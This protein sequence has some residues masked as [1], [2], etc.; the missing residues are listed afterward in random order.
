VQFNSSDA[1][2]GL[3]T[4]PTELVSLSLE[5]TG[6]SATRTATATSFT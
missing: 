3:E 5:G 4:I 2:S 1:L 6:Q